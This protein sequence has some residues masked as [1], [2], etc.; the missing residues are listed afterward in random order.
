LALAK[1]IQDAI[2]KPED[3]SQGFLNSI[4]FGHNDVNHK[5]YQW[6]FMEDMEEERLKGLASLNTDQ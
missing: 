2:D 6:N 3:A 5:N 4:G 1:S